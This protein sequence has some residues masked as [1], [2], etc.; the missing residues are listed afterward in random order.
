MPVTQVFSLAHA[1]LAEVEKVIKPFLSK[2]G[3]N[4]FSIPNTSL[5]IV[6]DY[7]GCLRRVAD[8]VE[9]MD[10]PGQGIQMRFVPVRYLAASD[11]AAQV[12]AILSKTGPGDGAGKDRLT[13]T[14][15]PRTNLIV[16]IGPPS[17]APQ[18][19]D[20]I[21]KLDVPV[22]AETRS[23]T[24]AHV[25]PQRVDGLVRNLPGGGDVKPRY[26]ATIDAE[27]GRLRD[28]LAGR[29]RAY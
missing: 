11:L 20:L 4:S 13:L 26:T 21:A 24:F 15:E 7:A 25:S 19:M 12:S 16:L 5:L 27:S 14:S 1:E 29:P 28:G 10:K 2:P 8:L 6:T 22:E 3:G 18:T 23:Y 9:M 17:L